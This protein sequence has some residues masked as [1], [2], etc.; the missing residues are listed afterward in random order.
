MI[1]NLKSDQWSRIDMKPVISRNP[2]SFILLSC[3][4]HQE[5]YN[6]WF[7]IPALAPAN[8]PK[9]KTA[10]RSKE[11]YRRAVPFAWM[12]LPICYI[13]HFY[14][15]SQDI[16]ESLEIAYCRQLHAQLKS[17]FLFTLEERRNWNG[18]IGRFSQELYFLCLMQG[19]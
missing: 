7:D 12:K 6:L 16:Q 10:D 1:C 17:Q 5:P 3:D 19:K 11:W 8:I 9:L 14:F 15:F 18:E 4:F 2:I 13:E